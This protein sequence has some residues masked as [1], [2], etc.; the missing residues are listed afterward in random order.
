VTSQSQVSGHPMIKNTA[1]QLAEAF[2][3]RIIA[4][5]YSAG[6]T[7]PSCRHVAGNL[8][9]DKNT[10]NKAYK[11]LER[12]GVVRAAP[13]KGVVVLDQP[14]GSVHENSLQ[15][16]L[17]SLVWEARALG[18]D[19]DTLWQFMAE[20]IWHYYGGSTVEVALIECN[21]AETTGMARE[22][23]ERLKMRVVPVLLDD[24]YANVDEYFESFDIIATTFYHL[25]E[26]ALV[27]G[28]HK[29]KLLGLFAIPV[30][31]DA[32]RIAELPAGTRL[33]VVCTER[34]TMGTLMNLIQTY[35][36]QLDIIGHVVTSEPAVADFASSVDVLMVT[37]STYALVADVAPHVP[38][39]VV[40]FTLDEQ[41][42]SF[43]KKRA[44]EI[45]KERL[46]PAH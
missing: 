16:R 9:I 28:A 24:F 2:L 4:G 6:D 18:V 13:G 31:D 43:L 12:K 45:A 44:H 3:H 46:T 30:T 35:S 27:A 36:T 1:E 39:I 22:L 37:M 15:Q 40:S 8:H 42:V 33:G 21:E 29:D 38:K 5:E 11:I 14:A 7:L 25:T 26:V 17:N 23:T 41:S 20:A 10:V 32:Q 19:E 34:T